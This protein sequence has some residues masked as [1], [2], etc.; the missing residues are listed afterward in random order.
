MYTY[1]IHTFLAQP[2]AKLNGRA[3]ITCSIHVSL[4]ITSPAMLLGDTNK[5]YCTHDLVKRSPLNK[6]LSGDANY[7]KMLGPVMSLEIVR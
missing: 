2:L 5:K 1:S 4:Q 3:Y 7:P 6:C